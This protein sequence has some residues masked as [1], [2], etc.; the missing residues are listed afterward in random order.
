[1]RPCINAMSKYP[2]GVFNK[3]VLNLEIRLVLAVFLL[4]FLLLLWFA[5]KFCRNNALFKG[6][7]YLVFWSPLMQIIH[8][9][10]VVFKIRVC[11]EVINT[12]SIKGLWRPFIKRCN[13]LKFP[14][15]L[16]S[17]MTD[18]ILCNSALSF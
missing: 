5:H 11:P 6:R 10:C 3:P 14:P 8:L 9:L 13:N 16:L 12:S 4:C 7:H 15:K 2:Q 17:V 1:M 18:A